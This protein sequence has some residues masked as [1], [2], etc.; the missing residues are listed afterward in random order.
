LRPP[1]CV[2]FDRAGTRVGVADGK[3]IKILDAA[4]G[5]QLSLA[6]PPLTCVGA[7]LSH[8]L[9]FVA[10]PNHQ[11][12]DLLDAT[13]GKLLRSL[14]DHRGA[15][16]R[17]ALTA[18]DRV[19]VAGS[20]VVRQKRRLTELRLW[21]LRAGRLRKVIDLGEGD[22]QALAIAPDGGLVAVAVRSGRQASLQLFD[23]AG[24]EVAVREVQAIHALAFS[25]DGKSLAAGHADGA[26]CLWP[27]TRRVAASRPAGT[28]HPNR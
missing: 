28:S 22:I 6:K 19:L 20:V 23:A 4:T 9:R 24:K 2:R 17:L 14:L 16:R 12:V 27:V 10:W 8:D 5:R 25:P 3:A 13:T 15:V 1:C 18:D 26:I 21:D 11:D 7:V